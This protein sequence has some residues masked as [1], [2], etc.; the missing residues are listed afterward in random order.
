MKFEAIPTVRIELDGMKH[1]IVRHLG[2]AGSQLGEAIEEQIQRAI[3][4]YP[5]E[6]QVVSITHDSITSAI[7]HYFSYGEG[8]RAIR[9]SVEAALKEV[10]QK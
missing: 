3:D 2:A 6:E 1:A 4:T 7:T 10:E 5:W 9:E 8:S